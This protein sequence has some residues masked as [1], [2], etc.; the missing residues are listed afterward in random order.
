MVNFAN[1]KRE[2]EDYVSDNHNQRGL[3]WLADLW[4]S[5]LQWGQTLKWFMIYE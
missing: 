4:H 3:V 2:K 5:R 1:A